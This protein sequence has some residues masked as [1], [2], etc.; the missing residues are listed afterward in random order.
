MGM[1]RPGIG[2]QASQHPSP[3]L[4]LGKHALD[5]GLDDALRVT[6]AHLAERELT[7]AARVPRMAVVPL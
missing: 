4:V 1:R 5:R 7:D 3:Q 6:L 2:F